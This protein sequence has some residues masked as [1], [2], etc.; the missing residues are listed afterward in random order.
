LDSLKDCTSVK[1]ILFVCH[2]T[3][4][5]PLRG[6][7]YATEGVDSVLKID[8]ADFISKMESFAIQGI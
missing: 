7:S 6:V 3:T 4:D 1:T 2:G 5:L 8:N